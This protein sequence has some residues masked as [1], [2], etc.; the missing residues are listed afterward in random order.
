MGL[1]ILQLSEEQQAEAHHD[2][3]RQRLDAPKRIAKPIPFLTFAEGNLPR[4]KDQHEQSQANGVEVQRPAAQFRPARP[5]DIPDLA[6]H[7][8]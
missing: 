3:R 2:D 6:P 5:S 1:E 4:G 8:S 7:T